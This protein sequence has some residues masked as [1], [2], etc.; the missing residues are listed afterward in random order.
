MKGKHSTTHRWFAC[1]EG[2][3]NGDGKKKKKKKRQEGEK[4]EENESK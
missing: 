1:E 4:W 3:S 2:R